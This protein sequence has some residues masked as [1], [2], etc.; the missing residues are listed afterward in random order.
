MVER[1]GIEEIIMEENN[2]FFSSIK[3]CNLKDGDVLIFE[4]KTDKNGSPYVP[5]DKV[6]HMYKYLSSLFYNNDIIFIFDKIQ[7][8][9]VK[10]RK[11]ALKYLKDYI[12]SIEKEMG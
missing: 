2:K 12:S 9:S 7:P 5:L 8:L 10:K 3:K 1:E 11:E 4:I 6:L